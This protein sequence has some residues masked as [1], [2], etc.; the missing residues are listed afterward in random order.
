M[1]YDTVM[2]RPQATSRDQVLAVAE[3]LLAR[4]GPS[5]VTVRRIAEALGVSRQ[6]VYSRFADKADLVRALHAEGFARLHAR[7]AG[8][9]GEPGTDAH[10]RAVGR[11]YREAAHA[12]PALFELMFGRP[13]PEFAP[14][15]EARAVAVAAFAPV[16]EAARAWL[17]R[18]GLPSDDRASVRLARR[19]WAVTHGVVSLELS[20]LL[21]T[22]AGAMLDRLLGAVLADAA[23]TDPG[24]SFTATE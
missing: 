11:A 7:A 9:P 6:I 20:G 15:D 3:D 8:A 14:D 18:R 12:D 19:F 5:A 16:V 4:E 22:D 23:T 17:A 2:P 13:V 1:Y 21:G 24:P 10:V